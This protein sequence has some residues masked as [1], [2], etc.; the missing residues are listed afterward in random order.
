[1]KAV[2]SR[3]RANVCKSVLMPRGK[4]ALGND[5]LLFGDKP[6]RAKFDV[7]PR[8]LLALVDVLRVCSLKSKSR[9]HLDIK[10]MTEYYPIRTSKGL[11][12][13]RTV[14]LDDAYR[15]AMQGLSRECRNFRDFLIEILKKLETG[16]PI[17]ATPPPAAARA[18][19]TRPRRPTGSGSSAH[20][21]PPMRT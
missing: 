13:L 7:G 14:D 4:D 21:R 3:V 11:R 19:R 17:N 20:E 1:V 16:Q 12:K 6:I 15:V 10:G 2:P 8:P 9:M 18:T 5:V